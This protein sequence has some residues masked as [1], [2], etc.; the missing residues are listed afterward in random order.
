MLLTSFSVLVPVLFVMALGYWAGRT[1]RFDA[2]QIQGLNELV[3]TYALPALMFV[4]AV[5]TRRSEMLAEAPFLAGLLVAFLGL[6]IVVASVSVFVLR[7]SVGEAALQASLFTFPSAAF[8]GVPI[9]KGIFGPASLLSIAAASVLACITILPLSIVMLEIGA[10]HS[11]NK[12]NQETQELGKLIRQ[13]L[14]TSFKKPMVWAP[15]LGAAIVL[16]DID[17]PTEIDTMLSLIG[18]TTGGA[19]LFLA[20]LVIATY[21][22]K[23][24]REVLVN[25]LGKMLLQPALM[26][27]LVALFAIHNPLGREAI[28]IGAIPATSIVPIFAARYKVYEAESA[29]TVVIDSLLMLVTFTAAVMLVGA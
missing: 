21:S 23:F 17:F 28:L 19:S 9:F 26:A 4:A 8:F 24:N 13:G 14:I 5:T 12:T 25:V 22:I 18:S 20:G 2:D 10:Q 7:H 11:A 16:L 1:K 6:F 29:S 3:I 15:L 27:A